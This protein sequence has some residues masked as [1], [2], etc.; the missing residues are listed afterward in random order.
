MINVETLIN[1]F[2]TSLG[3][4]DTQELTLHSTLYGAFEMQERIFA[5]GL[6]GLTD[7]DLAQKTAGEANT[8]GWLAG[9]LIANRGM[10]TRDLGGEYL[11]EREGEF[12]KKWEG[13]NLPSKESFLKEWYKV[14]EALREQMKS[15]TEEEWDREVADK[16]V[17]RLDF[18]V[19]LAYH[20]AYHIGQIGYARRVIGL[21]A[22]QSW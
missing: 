19:F 10:L 6:E 12:F 13:G 4:M 15:L 2:T 3:I 21:P 8:I 1:T 11:W 20:E 22:M 5:Q 14:S 17:K 7:N 16:P 9:H 18:A